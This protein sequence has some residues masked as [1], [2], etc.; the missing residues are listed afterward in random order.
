MSKTKSASHAMSMLA[1]LVTV[2]IS[3]PAVAATPSVVV[4]FN[5]ALGQL[6]ES[7]TSASDGSLYASNV[8]G[9]IQKIDPRSGT[10]TAVATVALPANASL[11]GIK[12]GPDGMI[13]VNSA[14]F[15]ASPAGAFVWRVSPQTGAVQQFA[16][17]DPNGF[18]DDLV[19]QSD[20]SLLVTDGFL[21]QI[22]K[23]DAAGH[24]AV[25]LQDPLFDGDPSSPAFG[26]H[27]FGVDGIAW[28]NSRR[29]LYVDNTDFGRVM[30]IPVKGMCA[31]H[32]QVVAADPALK[33]ADGIAIDR[34][35]TV[36]TAVNTQNRIATVGEGGVISVIFEGSPLDGPSS[37]AFGTAHQDKLTLYISNFAIEDQAHPGVLS[38]PVDV[39]GA[40][41]R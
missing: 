25:W 18:P 16:A 29:N 41:L 8:S 35:G 28:D 3:G 5:P 34:S 12:V 24:A 1:A 33:G 19:F 40:P 13:Y 39:P 9:T 32:I 38:L 27:S 7:L 22:W 31:G 21:G 30:R 11:T 15:S 2:A 17:L 4:S 20:G 14:S 26:I 37:L 6:P 10:F 23:I 36:W